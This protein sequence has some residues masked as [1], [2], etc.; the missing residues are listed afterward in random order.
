MVDQATGSILAV[1]KYCG[2]VLYLNQSQQSSRAVSQSGHMPAIFVGTFQWIL[3]V[4]AS[5]NPV[6]VPI[7]QQ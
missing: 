1:A 7:W 2:I 5:A 4:A 3:L 6:A